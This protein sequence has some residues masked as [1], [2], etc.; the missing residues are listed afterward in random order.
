MYRVGLPGWKLAGR[1]GLPLLYRVD[2]VHDADAGVYVATSPDVRGLVAEAATFDEL[3]REV[4]AGA[5]ELIGERLPRPGV[6]L[7][8]AWSGALPVPA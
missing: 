1:L 2:V 8:A 7:R 5:S 3:F 6:A 4:Q